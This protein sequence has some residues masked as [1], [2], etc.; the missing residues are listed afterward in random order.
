MPKI[1]SITAAAGIAAALMGGVFAPAASADSNH[2]YTCTNQGGGPNHRVTC[3]GN[4]TLSNAL[5][6][7]TINVGD[8]NVLSDIQLR[9]LEAEL[10]EV[11][12]NHVNAPVLVQL[13]AL[14]EA[15]VNVYRNRLGIIVL[16]SAINVCS[17]VVR[18]CV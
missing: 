7:T 18:I 3:I 13:A 16:P 6:D 17:P 9:N 4:I 12:D 10:V 1:A 8:V 2:K 5:N 11:A 14:Q 15:V